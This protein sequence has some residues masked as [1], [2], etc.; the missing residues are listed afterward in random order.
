MGIQRSDSDLKWLF[1]QRQDGLLY[2]IS[3]DSLLCEDREEDKKEGTSG[4]ESWQKRA[5][6]D[7]IFGKKTDLLEVFLSIY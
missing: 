6:Q 2:F 3:R 4:Q 5:F 1:T 7:L